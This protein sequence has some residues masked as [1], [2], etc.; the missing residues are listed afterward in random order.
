MKIICFALALIFISAFSFAAEI[1]TDLQWGV[2]FGFHAKNGYFSSQQAK[3]EVEAMAKAGATWVTVVP[4]VWQDSCH[5][6][7]QYRDFIY[8]PNDI[9]L[10]DIIDFTFRVSQAPCPCSFL[11]LLRYKTHRFRLAY[12]PTLGYPPP[13]CKPPVPVRCRKDT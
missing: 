2:T 10:L 8:T 6:T 13:S 3:D 5:S 7:F 12:I 11:Y 9:E 4:T 1:P